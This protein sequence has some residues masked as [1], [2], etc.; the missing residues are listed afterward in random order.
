MK[1]RQLL[2][3]IFIDPEASVW[4]PKEGVNVNVHECH[5]DAPANRSWDPAQ[6]PLG[7]Y[8]GDPG[9]GNMFCPYFAGAESVF[10]HGLP[11]VR[12]FFPNALVV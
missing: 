12:R 6:R 10:D 11:Q 1:G 4:D 5:L 8:K 7:R 3:P 9:A 2:G